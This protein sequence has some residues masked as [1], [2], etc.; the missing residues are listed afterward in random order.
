MDDSVLMGTQRMSQSVKSVVGGG[1]G[2][3]GG[4]GELEGTDANA[5]EED[6]LMAAALDEYGRDSRL[7]GRP[8]EPP[9]P[10]SRAADSGGA[11]AGLVTSTDAAGAAAL[12]AAAAAAAAAFERELDEQDPLHDTLETAAHLRTPATLGT[13]GTAGNG[14]A[15]D[16]LAMG[17]SAA[18]TTPPP[19][20]NGEHGEHGQLGAAGGGAAGGGGDR[21]GGAGEDPDETLELMYNPILK[22]YYDPSTGKYYQLRDEDL[23]EDM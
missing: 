5:D 16:L 17:G 1:G 13:A 21:D 10:L 20:E 9:L 15:N 14:S 8:A 22:C 3:G 18:R 23:E 7:W 2:G 4:G 11:G 19:G 6:S 12:S